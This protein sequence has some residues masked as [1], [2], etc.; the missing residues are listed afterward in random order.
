MKY[1]LPKL[2]YAY[3][4]LEPFIDEMTMTIHHS[5]HHQAYVDNLNAALEKHPEIDRFSLEELLRRPEIVPQDIQSSVKNNGGGH[6]NHT[7]F[8]KL[9][10]NNPG[11]K[12][13]GELL[14]KIEAV[15]G[16]FQAFQEAFTIA[17]K[18]R[19]GSGWVWLVVNSAKNL[20]IVSTANQD[21]PFAFGTPLLALDVWE[22]AYY[23]KYQNRRADYIAAFFQIINW[24]FVN[25]LFLSNH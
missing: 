17:A 10:K 8:W 25:Q 21:V 7:F 5:K 3:N 2:N 6:Y 15:F 19:F 14:K 16:S 18:G 22:H 11:G 13:T 1:T 23:L 4:A 9:L 20:E 12:P 24:D